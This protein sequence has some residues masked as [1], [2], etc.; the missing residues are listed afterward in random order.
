MKSAAVFDGAHMSIFGISAGFFIQL[1]TIAVTTRVF[2]QPGG[3][4]IKE[5]RSIRAMVMAWRCDSE[6]TGRPW[7]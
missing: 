4:W 3:P 7:T 1:A 2:P 5:R 6:K